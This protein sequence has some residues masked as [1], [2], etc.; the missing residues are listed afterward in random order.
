MLILIRSIQ[1]AALALTVVASLG[2]TQAL[3]DLDAT[4]AILLVA[5]AAWFAAPLPML[6]LKGGADVV[7]E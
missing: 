1:I 7:A 3:F 5:T 4:K 6:A 2:Y